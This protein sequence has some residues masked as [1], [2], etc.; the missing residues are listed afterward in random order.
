[1]K[2]AMLFLCCLL[3][4]SLNGRAD[5]GTSLVPLAD[6][7]ILLDGDTYYAYG[8]H[9]GSGIEVW[10]S[11]DLHA[12][13]NRG[14]ALDKVN[15][16]ETQWFWA[17]EVY[18]KEGKYYMYYSAN[19]HL[20]TATADSP[21]G[22]FKQ[23]GGR[24]MESLIG[25][26]KCIDSSV[27]FD[28]DGT[29]YIFFVRFNDGNC[30]WMAE[31]QDDLIT[32]V[33]GTLK[34]CFAVSQS[35]ENKMGRVNEG[36]NMIKHNGTYYLTYSGND[37]R[38]QDYAVGYATTTS[39]KSPSWTKYTSNPI[40]RRVEGLMGTGHHSLFTDK[41]GKLRIVFHAHESATSVGTRRMYIGTMQFNSTRLALS[42][43]PIIRPGTIEYPLIPEIIDTSLGYQRGMLVPCDL[44]GD[45][46]LDLIGAGSGNSATS[47]T[48]TAFNR[49]RRMDVRTYS[50]STHRW[51]TLATSSLSVAVADAPS[52]IPCDLNGDGVID[53]VAFEAAGTVAGNEAY[54]LTE[55]GVFLGIRANAFTKLN[56]AVEGCDFDFDIKAP[57][58]ACVLDIDNDG[59]AD[60]VCTGWQDDNRYNLVLRN[61][62]ID[63][64]SITFEA[65]AFEPELKLNYPVLQAADFNND[66]YCDF[67]V[68][69][70]VTGRADLVCMTEIYLN[71]PAHPGQF[72]PLG[73]GTQESGVL[74]KYWGGIGVAD[75]N[76][77]GRLDFFLAGYGDRNTGET[78]YRQR[79]FLNQGGSR[80]TFTAVEDDLAEDQYLAQTN[81]GNGAGIIDW[82]GDGHFDI[83]V[84][85]TSS[86]NS[87]SQ[88][89]LNDGTGHMTRQTRMP[90][91]TTPS[92]AFVDW[93]GDGVK[94]VLLT[95]VMNNKGYVGEDNQGKQAIG[96]YNRHAAPT[97]P[98]QP[99]GCT[100]RTDG[101]RVTLAWQ[102]ATN[103]PGNETYE[104]YVK[105]GEGK[106]VVNCLSVVS[107]RYVGKRRVNQ[108][109]NAGTNRSMT[110]TL[111]NGTYTWGVQ[112]VNS[113]YEASAFAEGPDFTIETTGIDSSLSR[114]GE[115]AGSSVY[116]L[117][118]QR[119][120]R[121]AKGITIRKTDN[122][123]VR[124]VVAGSRNYE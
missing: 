82:N 113:A 32:P 31:L 104:V 15:T 60:I 35:W 73:L 18:Y 106:M 79:V 41:E 39:L 97:L 75:F 89:Y 59:L 71:N 27:F 76:S 51:N 50:A 25:D 49:T 95:G 110:Y 7:Y 108:M 81:V 103:A 93:N 69:A 107:G 5:G 23:E 98:E 53:L 2:K 84:S 91:V 61:K 19:E 123:K 114:P 11:Q 92:I 28:D 3:A 12:W 20:Y 64:E 85:G 42:S 122:G 57:T 100:A 6:P 21:L 47:E 63:G 72:T 22:P 45:G 36:P 54:E 121:P 66:G 16:T 44:N 116:N 112:A 40:V 80:P 78:A 94:D 90:G 38:S 70:Q 87:F 33:A 99:T 117:Q 10:T 58:A 111:P 109:G 83:F 77:D 119:L 120:N 68:S 24:Q 96:F 118:G 1:M 14:L 30:I 52:L 29:T 102:P 67:I 55:Q 105:N 17:P 65:T 13:Q 101:N 88:L 48:G 86:N 26:E 46:V 74:R 4:V 37:Y 124:K 8:T 43:E 62:G 34:K 56:V 115:P 9:S